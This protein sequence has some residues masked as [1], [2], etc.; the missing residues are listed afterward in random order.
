MQSLWIDLSSKSP[1][2]E[3]KFQINA[4]ERILLKIKIKTLASEF[5]VIMLV[6]LYFV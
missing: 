5:F 3:E 1:W 4:S 2:S 6:T